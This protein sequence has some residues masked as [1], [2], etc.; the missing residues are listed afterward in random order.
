M[1][2]LAVPLCACLTVMACASRPQLPEMPPTQQRAKP[3][4]AMG[5]SRQAEVE[6]ACKFQAGVWK[7]GLEDQAA[8]I[9]NCVEILGPAFRASEADR[10]EL[11][12]WIEAE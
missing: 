10:A 12:R 9:R 3:L 6:A 11:V 2:K 1:L 5:P 7:L 8:F 4:Q